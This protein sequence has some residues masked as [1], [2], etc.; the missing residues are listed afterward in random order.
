[1]TTTTDTKR[2]PRCGETVLA[3]AETCK[4][5]GSRGID[6]PTK[7]ERKQAQRDRKAEQRKKT[8]EAWNRLPGPAKVGIIV[9]ALALFGLLWAT[10]SDS[11]PAGSQGGE[12]SAYGACRDYVKDQLVSPS[13]ASFPSL[14]SSEVTVTDNGSGRWTVSGPVDADNSF[15]ASLR[16]S[17]TCTVRFNDG[18]YDL[19]SVNVR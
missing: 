11:T 10:S 15:G 5:C 9:G 12:A 19:V 13:S 17:F 8:Q 1:M 14:Y 16:S 6:K 18:L 2:C 3:V 7:A 4:H